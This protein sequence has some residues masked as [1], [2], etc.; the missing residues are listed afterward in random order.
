MIPELHNKLVA[1]SNQV[2]MGVVSLEEAVK[3]IDGDEELSNLADEQLWALIE[4]AE[5]YWRDKLDVAVKHPENILVHPILITECAESR[6]RAIGQLRHGSDDAAK[7][8]L[9][10][11]MAQ[12]ITNT[13]RCL[14]SH[15]MAFLLLPDPQR[16]WETF[17]RADITARALPDAG[18]LRL[19]E[20]LWA[21]YGQI[22]ASQQSDTNATQEMNL[23]MSAPAYQQETQVYFA[24]VK[25]EL[26]VFWNVF[27]QRQ[28]FLKSQ[29]SASPPP[30]EAPKPSMLQ[31]ADR[32]NSYLRRIRAGEIQLAE[33]K[34][35]L[36][37]ETDFSQLYAGVFL[38]LSS[39]HLKLSESAPDQAVVLAELNYAVASAFDGD[40]AEHARS[41]CRR[42]LGLALTDRAKRNN[43]EVEDFRR[44][45]LYLEEA[46]KP[47]EQ[48]QQTEAALQRGSVITRLALCYRGV[49][50]FEE[51]KRV[52]LKA[53]ELWKAIDNS[54][55]HAKV[56]T[57]GLA[58]AYGNLA[59]VQ[60]QLGDPVSAF[61]NHYQAFQLFLDAKDLRLAEQ[62]LYNLSRLSMLAGRSDDAISALE[63]M[64]KLRLKVADLR[65]A[66]ESYLSL[67][68][69]RL[70][71]GQ[72]K[73]ALEAFELAE[74]LLRPVVSVEQPDEKY[75]SLYIDALIWRG[76]VFTLLFK[77][78]PAEYPAEFAG[79]MFDEAIQRSMD[80]KDAR[81]FAKSIL[82]S[83]NLFRLAGN[84][85]MAESRLVNLSLVHVSPTVEAR[86][87]EIIGAI[88]VGQ[89]RYGEA[90]EHLQKALET[91][92][93]EQVDRRMATLDQIGQ[94][95]EG[96]GQLD[97]AIKSYEAALEIFERLR[98]SLYEESRMQFMGTAREI[99]ERLVVLCSTKTADPIRALY[100]LEKSKSRTFAETMGLSLIPAT[101]L[102]AAARS[103][104]QVEQQFLDRINDI[105]STLFSSA[106]GADDSLAAQKELHETLQ[107]L[108]AL[109]DKMAIQ[110]EEYV[111]LRRGSVISWNALQRLLTTSPPAQ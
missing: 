40:Q 83:A 17:K 106:G 19:R 32:L 39:L 60:E 42:V 28:Q 75:L 21:T 27:Q 94:A 71:V 1:V 23:I 97:E 95:Y 36:L 103:D 78:L 79:R 57:A 56:R 102:P 91:Y 44:A 73:E 74:G 61:G 31:Y 35:Q 4:E 101:N 48:E 96:A 98:L 14:L 11:R 72:L 90:V 104:W 85:D 67:G 24:E 65:G 109:W 29:S 37:E 66:V 63:R 58:A 45:I 5:R 100:W 50:N 49:G 30:P 9:D 6:L 53:V 18:R 59:D 77:H 68:E 52:N 88:R 2:V 99:Y 16:A 64:A 70:R 51:A 20:V 107:R 80:I 89:H 43:N 47:L 33:A 41:V 54:E 55:S 10:Q 25:K 46:L 26:A 111:A 81:R 86:S 84:N 34:Q 87:E 93:P 3:I 108:N 105:R 110:C 82:Q 92:P 12:W 7:P 62:A 8:A 76:T 13:A 22:I 15:A 69:N 38:T